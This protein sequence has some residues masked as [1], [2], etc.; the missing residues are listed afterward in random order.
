MSGIYKSIKIL[1]LKEYLSVFKELPDYKKSFRKQAWVHLITRNKL[2]CPISRLK[3]NYCSL[4][5]DI[6]GNSEHY[7]FYS[8]Y[9]QL[10]TIDHIIPKSK[11]GKDSFDNIQ[12]ML[13]IENSRKSNSV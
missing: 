8:K 4:D 12:P 13:S 1:T 6:K 2:T 9:G 10:I 3:V 5:V 7:N 11:G